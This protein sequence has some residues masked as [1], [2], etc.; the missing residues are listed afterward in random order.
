MRPTPPP[1]TDRTQPIAGELAGLQSARPLRA[2]KWWERAVIYQVLPISF[3]DSNGDGKGDLAG[4]LNRIEYL[5]WL[6]V[7]AVWLTPFYSSPFL[8]LGYDI[9]DFCNVDPTF[10]TL[11]DVDRLLAELHAHGIKL[12][13][14]FVPNHTSNKHPWF[15]ESRTSRT[16]PKRDWH[17]WADPEADGG[18]PNN[19]MSRFGG[20]AWHWEEMR[21]QYYYHSFLLE[22]G[23]GTLLLSTYHD[24]EESVV[25]GPM[26]LRPDES[27]IIKLRC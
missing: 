22:Q 9:A 12:I 16:N 7:D 25:E 23:T 6:G 21:G 8:D 11:A 10:G 17:I 15:S 4:L 27:V 13:I 5:R 18:P 26:L 2:P 20:S 1:P 19:W 14:D 24:R 3:Q